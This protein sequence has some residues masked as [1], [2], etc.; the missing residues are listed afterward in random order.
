MALAAA[1]ADEDPVAVVADGAVVPAAAL[2]LL[3]LLLLPH[4]A[5]P[6]QAV[7]TAH[8]LVNRVSRPACRWGTCLISIPLFG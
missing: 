5:T 3:L 1:R 8:R 6:T 7:V 2:L 4:A